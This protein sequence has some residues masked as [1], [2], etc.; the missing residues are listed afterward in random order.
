[1]IV[2]IHQPQYIPWIC[3]F[4]KIKL[5]NI[6]I[7]LDTV[8]YQKNGLQNRNKI[9]TSQGSTWLTI[10]VKHERGR[11]IIDIEIDN[12]KR[13]REKHWNTICQSYSKSQYFKHY[14]KNLEEIYELE[15]NNL[16]HLN[17]EITLKICEWL[18]IKTKIIRSSDLSV[19]GKS[20]N[21]ILNLCKEKN[22]TTYLSGVG[23]KNYLD[24]REFDDAGIKI[25]YQ[26]QNLPKSYPQL[27]KKI[28]FI[29]DLS[30][31]DLIFNCGEKCTNYL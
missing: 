25:I 20:S 6:F 5:S 3:Y 14:K 23:G 28:G 30:V 18:N 29:N 19:Q 12:S 10:P 13:W 31:L 17:I 9:K 11:K 27:Y 24:T 26:N 15:W 4:T 7:I 2:S 16:S 22:A 21:L 8:D 1:M